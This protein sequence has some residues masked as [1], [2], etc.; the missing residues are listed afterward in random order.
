MKQTIIDNQTIE[1][2]LLESR[3]TWKSVAEKPL[4][5]NMFNVNTYD[6]CRDCYGINPACFNFL[7]IPCNE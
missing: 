1:G 2:I 6:A 3:C 5:Q 4:N 7:S